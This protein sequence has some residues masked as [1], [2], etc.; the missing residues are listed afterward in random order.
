[1]SIVADRTQKAEDDAGRSDE[2]GKVDGGRYRMDRGVK[3]AAHNTTRQSA[4]AHITLSWE[5]ARDLERV[6][7]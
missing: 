4:K 7:G 5:L 2:S 6:C 3:V 1:M